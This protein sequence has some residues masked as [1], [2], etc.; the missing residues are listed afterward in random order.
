[1]LDRVL[2][3]DDGERGPLPAFLAAIAAGRLLDIEVL[4]HIII[5]GAT[6]VSL[7]DHGSAFDTSIPVRH[8]ISRESR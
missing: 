5:G 1:M 8:A 4:D 3:P 6:F 7:R 2:L